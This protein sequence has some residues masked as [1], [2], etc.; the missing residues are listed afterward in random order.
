MLA[1]LSTVLWEVEMGEAQ[2]RQALRLIAL[3]FSK[4]AVAGGGEKQMSSH[5]EDIERMDAVRKEIDETIRGL[6][7][8]SEK[9]AER[10]GA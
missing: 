2:V 4:P 6:R 7:S 8:L 5:E 3:V 9:L 10:V 1:W